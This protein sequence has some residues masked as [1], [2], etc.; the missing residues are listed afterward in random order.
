LRQA[1]LSRPPILRSLVHRKLTQCV[2]AAVLS[3]LAAFALTVALLCSRKAKRIHKSRLSDFPRW[4]IS[5]A[6]SQCSTYIPLVRKSGS[7]LIR[8]SLIFLSR[9]SS[10]RDLMPKWSSCRRRSKN[11]TADSSGC[12]RMPGTS[13]HPR[14]R[15]LVSSSGSLPVNSV[16]RSTINVTIDLEARVSTPL[17]RYRNNAKHHQNGCARHSCPAPTWWSQ[18]QASGSDSLA[19]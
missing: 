6:S 1:S 14:Y 9:P 5:R 17:H 7:A 13:L 15:C 18:S 10:Q 19:G 8:Q 12:L 16:L 11:F 2:R 4:T 3:Q